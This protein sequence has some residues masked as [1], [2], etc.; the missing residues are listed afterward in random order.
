MLEKLPC[1]TSAPA[2]HCPLILLKKM[3]KIA[4]TYLICIFG[5]ETKRHS[6][7]REM[8]CQLYKQSFLLKIEKHL[9]RSLVTL[10][11]VS[12]P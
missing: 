5:S 12:I 6:Y 2:F 7:N 10:E 1:D 11:L 3:E 9:Q 8:F 4:G